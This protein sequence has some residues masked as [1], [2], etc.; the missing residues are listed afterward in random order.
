MT[1]WTAEDVARVTTRLQNQIANPL[2]VSGPLLP[3]PR[4]KYGNVKVTFQGQKFESEGELEAY[5]A[6]K[7]QELAGAIRSVIRQVSMP[8]QGTNRRIRLD[9]VVVENDGRIRWM[10]FKGFVTPAW[11][12]KRDQVQSAYGIAIE[13]I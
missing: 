2:K 11:A 1:R 12:F 13:L 4:P 5:K 8:L 7:L 9:F 3:V 6:F 10:D